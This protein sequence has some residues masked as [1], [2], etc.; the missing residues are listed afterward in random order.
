MIDIKEHVVKDY[1]KC[2]YCRTKSSKFYDIIFASF[3]F[4]NTNLFL[5]ENCLL[6]L[7]NKIEN[8]L[9]VSPIKQR[10]EKFQEYVC[11]VIIMAITD[12]ITIVVE[13]PVIALA[14]IGQM[15]YFKNNGG[16]I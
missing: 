2:M 16:I 9:V 13:Y 7:K 4:S 1:M 10:R 6:E 11:I 15:I 3:N 14:N 8:I 12:V 5:C